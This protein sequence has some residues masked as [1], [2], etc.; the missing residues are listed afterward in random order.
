MKYT[1]NDFASLDV[2]VELT[3]SSILCHLDVSKS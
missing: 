2:Q 1:K 3:S